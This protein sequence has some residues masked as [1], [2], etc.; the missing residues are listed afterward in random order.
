METPLPYAA[1]VLPTSSPHLSPENL[2]QLQVARLA[3]RKVRRAASMAAFDGWTVGSFGALTFLLGLPDLSSI[4]L[5]LG[6]VAIAFV[7]IRGGNRLKRLDASAARMLAWNQVVLGTLLLIY[8]LWRIFAVMRAPSGYGEALAGSDPQ[9]QEMLAPVEGL[10]RVV[11]MTVYAA[12]IAIAIFGQ[13][14]MALYYYS[15][16]KH[17]ESYLTHTPPWIIAMQRAGVS[18]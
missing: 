5:G 6:M 8:S 11:M 3:M 13:G 15:R 1:P 9:L 14:S 4:L 18:V 10:T 7:E 2:Q 12:L 16:R 17:V